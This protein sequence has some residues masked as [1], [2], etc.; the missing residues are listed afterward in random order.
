MSWQELI[1]NS[2]HHPDHTGNPAGFPSTTDLIVGPGFKKTFLPGYPTDPKGVI[3]E[4]DYAGRK[5]REVNFDEESGGLR[6]GG[7]RAVDYFGDGS[8]YLLE[9][10]GVCSIHSPRNDSRVMAHKRKAHNRPYSRSSTNFS[11]PTTIHPY[12]RRSR[13]P[14]LTMASQHAP[15]TSL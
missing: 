14:R 13:A 5:L 3:L 7:F 6:I 8:F 9:T 11:L 2:H 15:L 4:S 12:G 1:A 10:P